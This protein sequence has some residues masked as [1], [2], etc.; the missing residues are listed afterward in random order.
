MGKINKRFPGQR[1]IVNFLPLVLIAVLLIGFV[2]YFSVSRL[3]DRLNTSVLGESS[4]NTSVE[5]DLES[6]LEA[7]SKDLDSVGEIDETVGA[8]VEFKSGSVSEDEKTNTQ[9]SNQVQ[10]EAGS[11]GDLVLPEIKGYKPTYKFLGVLDVKLSDDSALLRYLG[12]LFS[13]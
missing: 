12:F 8:G 10:A 5:S 9:T 13:K 2:G 3:R 7:G 4:T 1:G 11:E 6:E